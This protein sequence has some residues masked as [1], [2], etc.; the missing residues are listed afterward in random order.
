MSPFLHDLLGIGG[1]GQ[2]EN[3]SSWSNEQFDRL[4]SEVNVTADLKKSQEVV[5]QATRLIYA[6]APYI[7]LAYPFVL[8]AFRTDCFKGWGEDISLWS[9]CPFDRLRPV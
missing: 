8:E 7:M 3:T 9:Y 5:D 4:R 1:S 2:L 6:E